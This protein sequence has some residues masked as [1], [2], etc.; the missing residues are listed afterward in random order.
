MGDVGYLDDAGRFWYCGRK[1]HRVETN[2]GTL[3]TECVEAVFN[4]HPSV[5]RSA[6]VG[7]STSAGK[8][9][10]ICIEP[11]VEHFDANGDWYPGN[12]AYDGLASELAGIASRE[13]ARFSLNEIFFHGGFPVDVRH[14]A[15][16]NRE[17]LAKW[18]VE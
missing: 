13:F 7:I 8:T 2:V 5:A 3:Y 18:V 16:I 17:T 9:P 10:V 15:K 4:Q 11:T 12:R 14:N 6:L 1:S